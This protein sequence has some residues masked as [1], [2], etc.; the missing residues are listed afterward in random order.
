MKIWE[1]IN[2][3]NII[4]W[5]NTSVNN[6]KIWEDTNRKKT[7]IW[8]NGKNIEKTSQWSELYATQ[9]RRSSKKSMINMSQHIS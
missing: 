5:E 1:G 7:K 2:V 3:K 8:E 6:M 4:T 9:R